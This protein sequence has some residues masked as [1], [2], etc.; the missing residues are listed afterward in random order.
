MSVGRGGALSRVVRS[1]V[2]RRRVPTLVIGLA[3]LIAVAAS[4]LAG[5]LIVVS[6]APFDHAFA[7]QRGAHLSAGFDATKVTQAQLAA[8]AQAPGVT[9]AAGPFAAAT[10]DG[11]TLGG[12]P[13]DQFAGPMPSMTIVGRPTA[14]GPVDDLTLLDGRWPEAPNEIVLSTDS[15]P[16]GLE[17]ATVTFT[18]A[19]GSPVFTIVGTAQ[20]VTRTAD[21][22]VL[23]SQISK[24]ATPGATPS[25]QMLYRFTDV[26]TDAQI[27]ADR[28]EIAGRLPAGALVG[29]ASYLNAKLDADGSTKPI[30]PFVVAFGVLGLIMS[31]IVVGNVVSGSVGAG[32]R[33]IG[34]LKALGFTPAQVVRAYVAQAVI[35]AAVGIVL[36]VLLGNIAARPLLSDTERVY[37]TAAL[38]VAAWVNVAVPVAALAVVALAALVPA[39]RAGRLS[40]VEAIAVGRTPKA[41]RGRLA[42]R[43]LNRLPLP[44]AV[45]LGLANPFARPLRSFSVAA[46]I[47]FGALAVTFG[48]GLAASLTDVQ[49]G[50]QADR[51]GDVEV[52]LFQP[53]DAGG[54]GQSVAIPKGGL[55]PPVAADPAAISAAIA[56]QPGTA[57][58]VGSTQDQLTVAGLSGSVVVEFYQGKT[59]PGSYQMIS[60]SWY[61]GP[62]QA[63]AP[64][65][66]LQATGTH[67]G[68]QITVVDHGKNYPVRIVGEVFSTR[69]DGMS[70]ITDVATVPGTQVDTYSINVTSGTSPEAYAHA[71]SATINPLGAGARPNQHDDNQT[72]ALMEA[73]ITILTLMLVTVA[74]LGVLN[75]TVLDTRDRV[76]DLGVYKAIGMTPRQTIAMVL[77]SVAAIGLAAGIVGVP[78]GVKLHDYILPVMAHGAGTNIPPQDVS[79]YSAAEFVLLALGGIVIAMLGAA[80]PAG[81]AAKVRTA[82]ALRTE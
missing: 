11:A 47:L 9:A 61:T 60:G 10:V 74:G 50:I 18:S 39:L 58:Y 19:P 34:I 65:R 1:G 57:G 66:F 82:S 53:G 22:W 54:P 6:Q 29:T 48:V 38:S 2:G 63:L 31:V 55:V 3:A 46:A 15:A 26:A 33:R 28:A 49:K 45:S 71:L 43:V 76:H 8:T 23:P 24:I 36:G 12:Q 56:K 62:G 52:D 25:F 77:A 70:L 59:T 4:V 30:V 20:S 67:L 81:W 41:D 78:V 69:N 79:V 80:L 17:G 14:G 64:T 13:A 75:S 37:G 42:R 72:I 68:D 16:G 35:P 21:A 5:T 51:A 27:A 7:Q 73:M 32:V 40:A 44:R